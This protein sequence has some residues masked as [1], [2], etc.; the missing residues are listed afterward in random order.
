MYQFTRFFAVLTVL[1]IPAATFIPSSNPAWAQDDEADE[2]AP[3]DMDTD[4]DSN[5]IPDE[6]EAAFNEVK[7]VAEGL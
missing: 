5:G 4:D 6:F 3:I 2:A 1:A 7:A